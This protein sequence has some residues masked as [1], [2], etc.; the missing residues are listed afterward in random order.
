MRVIRGE[1]RSITIHHPQMEKRS[2][3][4]SLHMEKRSIAIT[5]TPPRMAEARIMIMKAF[6]Q[7][8]TP[9]L[10]KDGWPGGIW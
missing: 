8:I 2:I 6:H 7:P 9:R 3:T 1:K 4:I 10:E 5:P